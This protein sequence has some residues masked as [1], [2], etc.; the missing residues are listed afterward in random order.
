MRVICVRIAV[1]RRKPVNNVSMQAC[2]QRR[3]CAICDSMLLCLHM[4]INIHGSHACEHPIDTWSMNAEESTCK[5]T[6]RHMLEC[7]WGWGAHM[8]INTNPPT[9]QTNNRPTNQPTNRSTHRHTYA[10]Q[11][12]HAVHSSQ[13]TT[14][15]DVAACL[16]YIALHEN[17]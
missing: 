8:H 7:V 3:V 1:F 2:R 13:S 4:Q 9:Y 11:C 12:M 15:R 17:T 5:C 16:E 14:V 6:C 10:H